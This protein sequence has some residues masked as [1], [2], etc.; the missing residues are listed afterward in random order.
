VEII[1][2]SINYLAERLCL[3]QDRMLATIKRLLQAKSCKEMIKAGTTLVEQLF[4]NELSKFADSVCE[5]WDSVSNI[6]QLPKGS[7]SGCALSTRLRQLLPVTTGCLQKVLAAIISLSP[8]SM[9]VERI[10]SHYNNIRSPHRLSMTL[11]T[12]NDRLIISLNGV[13]TANFD[14]RP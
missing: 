14:P 3:E 13:G 4:P 1:A 9:Q 11:D 6:P 8:H 7:D 12:V 2:A 5:C 10:I